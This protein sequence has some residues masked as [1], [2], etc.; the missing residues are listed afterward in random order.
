MLVTSIFSFFPQCFLPYQRQILPL[1]PPTC[2]LSSTNSY[3][4]DKPIFCLS[5]RRINHYNEVLILFSLTHYH[6]M[7]HFDALKIYSCGKQGNK[8]FLLFLQC[9]LPYMALIYHFKSTLNCRLRFVS[10][11]TCLKFCRLVMG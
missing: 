10:I 1:E 3:I 7:P 9:F 8:Q 11:W 2:K 6:T 4:L 5:R